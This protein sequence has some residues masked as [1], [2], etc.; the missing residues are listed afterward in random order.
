MQRVIHRIPFYY[1]EHAKSIAARWH[2]HHQQY[3]STVDKPRVSTPATAAIWDKYSVFRPEVMNTWLGNGREGVP[4]FQ[5]TYQDRAVSTLLTSTSDVYGHR[6][7]IPA[8]ESDRNNNPFSLSQSL[9]E[10]HVAEDCHRMACLQSV[11]DHRDEIIGTADVD[12]NAWLLAPSFEAQ[13]YE[14]GQRIIDNMNDDVEYEYSV[15]D[16]GR[17]KRKATIYVCRNRDAFGN[18]TIHKYRVSG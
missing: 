4:A 11:F 14:A 2:N 18:E 8:K 7:V 9:W 5:K 10:H 16:K 3:R 6:D 12:T 13:T 1:H 15:D 17:R